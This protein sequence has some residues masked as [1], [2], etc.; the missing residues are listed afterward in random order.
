MEIVTV[1]PKYQVVIPLALRKALGIKAGQR[2][3]VRL[4]D[5]QLRLVPIRSLA[6]LRGIVADL[7]NDFEREPD[8]DL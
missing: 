6:E 8:R 7:K 5:G 4:E 3:E 2:F 1:S